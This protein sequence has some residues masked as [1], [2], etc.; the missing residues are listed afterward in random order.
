MLVLL[1]LFVHRLYVEDR[2][3]IQL[4]LYAN[5]SIVVGNFAF[6]SFKVDLYDLVIFD[7]FWPSDWRGN[8]DE[9]LSNSG[10]SR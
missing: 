6:S 5:L 3:M 1:F 7:H 8:R 4:L 9:F 10:N 2:Q